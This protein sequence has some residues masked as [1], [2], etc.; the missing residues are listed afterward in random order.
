MLKFN[1]CGGGGWLL[2][3][4]AITIVHCAIMVIAFHAHELWQNAKVHFC[5][6]H[7]MCQEGYLF[8]FG[9]YSG[10][11]SLSTCLWK[12]YRHNSHET[13]W[14]SSKEKD[15]FHRADLTLIKQPWRKMAP[16]GVTKGNFLFHWSLTHELLREWESMFFEMWINVSCFSVINHSCTTLTISQRGTVVKVWIVNAHVPFIETGG[17]ISEDTEETHCYL[18]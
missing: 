15:P 18:M 8:F 17:K 11:I 3:L 1:I 10:L 6:Y 5:F 4:S 9:L 13:W 7:L 14:K 12:N 16:E 2:L